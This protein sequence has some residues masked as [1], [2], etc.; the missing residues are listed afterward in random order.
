MGARSAVK[1]GLMQ[2][3]V[4]AVAAGLMACAA[5]PTV[6][7]DSVT[8]TAETVSVSDIT[9]SY[10]VGT[11][12]ATTAGLNLRTGPSTSRGIIL[13]MP[14]DSRVTLTESAPSGGFYH[15]RYGSTVGW[16]HGGY[17]RVVS[18]PG[19][20]SG[21]GSSGGGSSGGGGS[22]LEQGLE[23]ARAGVGFSYWWGGAHWSMSG[24]ASAGAGSCSGSCPSC[25][26]HGSNGA[27]CSGYV[28]KIW[29]V[30]AG[31]AD[32]ERAWHPYSTVDF[33]GGTGGGQWSHISRGSARR[34]DAFV[35]NSGGHGH[36]FL[37]DSGDPWGSMW[38][39]EAKGCSYGIVH[40]LRTASS[41][42]GVIRRNGW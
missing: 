39:Y 25:T 2:W 19:G 18:T 28:A 15:V 8:G 33:D 35:Y 41:A 29:G 11:V 4:A 37:F 17:L 22:A 12:L 32:V 40:D 3:T 1:S 21:G 24:P 14:N 36:I 34:G 42:Y 30:P 26:H 23:R 27:D 13:V 7:N 9:S 10:P 31:N 38:A 20:S 5:D 6:Q 16:A